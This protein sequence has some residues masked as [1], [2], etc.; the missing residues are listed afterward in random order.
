VGCYDPPV[1]DRDTEAVRTDRRR[2]A[3]IGHG[4]DGAVIEE[5]LTRN[6]CL[7][8]SGRSIPDFPLADEPHLVAW[9]RY[10]EEAGRVGAW[11]AL[12]PRFPQLQFPIRSGISRDER[13][14]QATL[15]G[16]FPATDV[17]QELRLESPDRLDLQLHP[18]IAGTV[19][20]LSTDQ[21]EDFVVLVRAFSARNEPIG[22]PDSMGACLVSGF[23]NWDRIGTYRAEWQAADPAHS[24]PDAW[25]V[26]FRRLLPRKQLYQDRFIILSGGPYSNVA[27]PDLG[28][29][30]NDWLECSL[31][32]RREHE[33]THY[34]SVRMFGL[35][36]HN[37]LE[38]L[39]ADFVGTIR[40]FGRY[41]ADAALRFL[42]LEAFPGYRAG[43]R[44][45]NYR[46]DPPISDAAFE[47]MCSLT[48]AAVQTLVRVADFSN[49][50]AAGHESLARLVFALTTLTL[51]ELASEDAL[52]RIDEML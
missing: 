36:Q 24:S 20:I 47:V 35:L 19:P 38:E 46:G 21:R 25:S 28:L 42:G 14:R 29:G 1:N 34:F 10:V 13:Y 48:H 9:R 52:E 44:V 23:N 26:E 5:L 7:V 37:V 8:D 49:Q 6:R 31:K 41:R 51:E 11:A 3:L 4:A 50:L 2:A 18:S 22:V 45:E 39:V 27:A 32:I 40:G 16:Q 15:R 17:F 43:G 33:C 30:E 12:R